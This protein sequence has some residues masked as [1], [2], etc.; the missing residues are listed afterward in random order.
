MKKIYTT[1]PFG[2]SYRITITDEFLKQCL[3]LREVLRGLDLKDDEDAEI[4]KKVSTAY[5]PPDEEYYRPIYARIKA[6]VIT[7]ACFWEEG[8][9]TIT[10]KLEYSLENKASKNKTLQH[11]SLEKLLDVWF[12]DSFLWNF[13]EKDS[14]WTFFDE[15]TRHLTRDELKKLL[16]DE[17]DMPIFKAKLQEHEKTIRKRKEEND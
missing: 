3:Q 2:E 9:E 6:D 8:W 1:G 4:T 5:P 14:G 15:K 13:T 16:I 7:L 17:E 11:V 12:Q 10:N